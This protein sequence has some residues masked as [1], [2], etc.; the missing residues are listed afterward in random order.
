M[1]TNVEL[2]S[3]KI[4]NIARFIALLPVSNALDTGYQLILEGYPTPI[5]LELSDAQTLKQIL[6]LDQDKIVSNSQSGWDKDKQLQKNQ[7]AIELL[8]ERIE[9][10]K[11]MSDTESLQ[12]QELFDEFKKTVDAQRLPG[13]KL[14]SDL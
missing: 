3:G 12:R 6:K 14:Y 10:H 4:L 1:K 8:A 7:R 11:N 5:D 13:Q 2:P 9:R